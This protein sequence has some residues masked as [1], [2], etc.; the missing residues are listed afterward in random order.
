MEAMC[1]RERSA[2]TLGLRRTQ[3][4]ARAELHWRDNRG[5]EATTV[6][7][8]VRFEHLVGL[9]PSPV[10]EHPPLDAAR[11]TSQGI[12]TSD[13]LVH[14]AVALIPAFSANHWPDPLITTAG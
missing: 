12:G 2:D 1:V 6:V 8:D 3:S 10:L 7:A 4:F 11:P 13:P 14:R 9:L 5:N